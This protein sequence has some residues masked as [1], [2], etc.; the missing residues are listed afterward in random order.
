MAATPSPGM[1]E[2]PRLVERLARRHDRRLTIVVGG[3]GA[4]KTTLLRQAIADV[5]QNVDALVA[6]RPE[7]RD[8]DRLLREVAEGLAVTTGST[9][10]ATTM[11]ELAE[12][13]LAGSPHDV[14]LILDDTHHLD[15]F[16][17]VEALLDVLPA[18]GHVLLAGRRRPAIDTARLDAAHQLAEITQDD[19][20]MTADEQVAF[21][22]L[23]GIDVSLLAGAEGWPAFV[24][25]AATGSTLRSR[26]YLEEE[27][28]RDVAP[29]RRRSLAAFAHVGGGDDEIARAVTGMGLD[30]LVTDLPLVRWENDSATLHDLWGELLRDTLDTD[31]RREAA[32]AAAAIHRVRRV[33]D[34]ALDLAMSAEAWDD[35]ALTLGVAVKDGVDGGLRAE[36]LHGWR[37]RLPV[38]LRDSP[39]GVL[40][41]GLVEREVDPTSNEA[42]EL[43]DRAAR[44]FHDRDDH[45]M[46]LVALLQ[47]GYVL[48]IVD[49]P[50]E[51]VRVRERVQRL[52]EVHPDARPYVNLVDT[53]SALLAGRP[54]IQYDALERLVGVDLP[55]V[56]RV[57]RD[58]LVAH[59][60]M[61]LGRPREALDRVPRDI[62]ELA[63]AIPGAL[64][65]HSQAL[66]YA[67]RP[68]D[69]LSTDVGGV[70]HGARDRFLA[71]IW[72]AAMHAIAGR[73]DDA[74]EAASVA[75][76]SLG[77][78]PSTLMEGQSHAV[79]LVARLAEGRDDEVAVEVTAILDAIPLG[80]GRGEQL[81][82]NFL[83]IPYVLV[84]SCRA[85]WDDAELGPSLR[86]MQKIA[87]AFVE[88]RETGA[89]TTIAGLA[90]PDPSLVAVTLPCRWAVEFA[91][92]GVT[93]GRHEGRQVAAWLCE[94]WGEPA[95]DALR[96]WT[97][98]GTLGQ[99][100]RETLA[101]TPTPP[102]HSTSIR[103]LGAGEV[104]ID[105]APSVD[106]NWRRERVRALLALLVL[107][108]QS[109]RE[110]LAAALWPD[111]APGAAA[112]NLRTTLNYLHS[113]LEPRR[114]A[115][116]ATWFV[117]ID[118]PQIRLN[119]ALQ[120]DVWDFATR[121][122][123]ADESERQGR[124]LVALGHLQAA[125]ALWTGDFATDLDVEHLELER[126][127][128]RSRFVRAACR[129]AELLVS[130]RR[131][132]E[133]IDAVRAALAVDPWH[134]PSYR[135]LADAYLAIDDPTSA[136]AVLDVGS[137]TLGTAIDHPVSAG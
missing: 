77:E 116:D 8:G 107:R 60:L 117:R 4:G 40:L 1:I 66:W 5:S 121:V 88:A 136:R 29:E 42:W 16:T 70:H 65:T 104:L 48:R 93:A 61:G 87:A 109:T 130:S 123:A 25:L 91:L 86:E 47:L 13:V 85:Y 97:D 134:E 37:Q 72:R 32:L 74:R 100:A 96:S 10:P 15:D 69:A 125:I 111:L 19:L 101:S 12:Q 84:P 119:P 55:P 83:A 2:R 127:H 62:G 103:L 105:G 35:V 59:A 52:G 78:A 24:E 106:A 131:P 30:E 31:E 81:F 102:D 90:W 89:L 80:P 118:G 57:T 122:D 95:R 108:R 58:H 99:A 38:E 41:D 43:F 137:R 33:T 6:C 17:L 9:S 63:V 27:A 112:K 11:D 53:W 133:A 128:L 39:L 45:E 92:W 115:G 76:A 26:R 67:G 79:E 110:Q 71:G 54:D 49:E 120:I 98:D 135:A 82:R 132:A 94:N 34:R 64:G 124:P 18:N 114:A 129:A 46:E 73:A 75:A 14:C 22:N 126:I 68:M 51:L 113:V 28:L 20:L 21:A 23:R 50:E 3:G 36:A 7:H 44:E 56:W